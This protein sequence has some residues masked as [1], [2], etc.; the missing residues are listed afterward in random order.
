MITT[1]SATPDTMQFVHQ[2]WDNDILPTL[3]EYIKIPNKSPHFDK[4]W[5]AHGYMDQ[6]VQLLRAWCERHTL[7]GMNLEVIQLENRTPII[8]LEIPGNSAETVLLYGHLDKQPEMTGWDQD[9]GPFKPVLRG[10]RLYGR[11]AA[12]DGYAIFASLTAIHIL[13]RQGKPH[14]R[15]IILIEACEESGSF[16]LPF[17][18]DHLKE[19][20]GEPSLVICLDSC[21]ENYDQLWATTSLRG[22]SGG[23]LTIDVLKQ[24]IHSGLG[25]G[26][27]PSTFRI[28]RQL[29]ERIED[30][31]T[32][33]IKLDELHVAIPN[34]RLH[35]AEL[36]AEVLKD[37][38]Y[39]D[40]PFLNQV[41]PES[42]SPKELIL[43]RTWKPA[44]SVTGCDGLPLIENAGNVTIPSLSV[45]LSIRLPPTCSPDLA[46]QTLK[47]TLETNPPYGATV[48]FTVDESVQGWNAPTTTPWLESAVNLASLEYFGKAAVYLGEGVSIPFMGMLGK[49]FPKA[50]FLI[51]GVLGPE[52]NAHGPNE[53]LHLPTAK[54]LTACVARVIEAH[55]KHSV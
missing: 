48:T 21:C 11:G 44:L 25:S 35:Q 55:F 33:N 15:C 27:V 17:Y 52:S 39:H 31:E 41:Q 53:F 9:L 24:G 43:R 38:V 47:S 5:Q 42:L 50:Q 37:A 6:A 18:I 19:R 22:I 8:F 34:D 51:T 14:A 12:D 49:K 30:K 1:N 29:L 46:M 23:T 7:P 2:I 45:K 20:M 32:G 26:I 40:L 36:A 4:N 3:M 54:K 13:Q 16:D 10:D 28:L